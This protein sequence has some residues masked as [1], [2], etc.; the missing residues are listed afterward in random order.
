MHWH[1][2][3]VPCWEGWPPALQLRPSQRAALNPGPT[4]P[5]RPQV[6]MVVGSGG[7]ASHPPIPWLQPLPLARLARTGRLDQL[8]LTNQSPPSG[9]SPWQHSLG[10]RTAGAWSPTHSEP[11]DTCVHPT[12]SLCHVA[13][14]PGARAPSSLS[15]QGHLSPQP[16]RKD[17]QE[18]KA[19]A[20]I[21]GGK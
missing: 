10:T 4:Q 3:G 7:G 6:V 16:S 2:W 20:S 17:R 18:R 1:S 11:R 5:R 9:L 14:P 19:T 21:G 12:A 13:F 15:V 8:Q